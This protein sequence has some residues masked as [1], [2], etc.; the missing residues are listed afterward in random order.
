VRHISCEKAA[1]RRLSGLV[2]DTLTT[3]ERD[4]QRWTASVAGL[5]AV[6]CRSAKTYPVSLGAHAVDH[7]AAALQPVE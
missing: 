2:E 6:I 3:N 5:E 4:E 7:G 1:Y